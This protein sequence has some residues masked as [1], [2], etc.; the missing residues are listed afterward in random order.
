[1]SLSSRIIVR[2]GLTTVATTCVA[3]GWLYLK[4]NH[5]EEYLS[6]RALMEQAQEIS[7][8]LAINSGGEAELR[9]PPELSE[10]YNSQASSFRYA[11]RDEAGRVVAKSVRDAGPVALLLGGQSRPNGYNIETAEQHAAYRTTVGSRR[12]T[13]EVSQTAPKFQSSHTDVFNEFLTDGGWLGIPFLVVLLGISAYTVKKSLLPLEKLSIAAAKIDPGNSDA[14]LPQADI[15]REFLPLMR[16]INCA[17]DRLDE[18]LR[19][20]RQF[21]TD[22]AHQLRTPLAA[23]L[24]NI[25]LMADNCIANRLRHDVELMSRIVSQ[26]LLIARLEA[27]NVALDQD[28]DLSSCAQEAAGTLA[29]IAIS[30]GKTIEIDEPEEVIH[31]RGNRNLVTAAIRNLTE[32]ALNHSPSGCAVRILVT[33]SPSV[34]VHDAGPGVPPN[35][36]EKIFERFWRGDTSQTGAGLGLSIVRQIMHILDGTVSVSGAPGGGA[37]FSLQF[38]KATKEALHV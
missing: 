37:M 23:L 36:R 18:G 34:E 32:N 4:Q 24:A 19:T 25:D 38:S 35:M 14:R 26:L 30:M 15:P 20:Q 12:F 11:V 10:A 22:A 13:I 27:P 16:A 17:L 8:Y 3:Y 7:M 1:M 29:P 21:T 2:L 28:V 9:L 6:Q 31:I 33:P 5:V